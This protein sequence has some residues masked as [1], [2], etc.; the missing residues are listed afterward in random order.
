MDGLINL[1]A[2]VDLALAFAAMGFLAA[3]VQ[4]AVRG[5]HHRLKFVP[6][7]LIA[8]GL[9]IGLIISLVVPSST[10]WALSGGLATAEDGLIRHT[11]RI[12]ALSTM[13]VVVAMLVIGMWERL[14]RFG[15]KKAVQ[16]TARLLPATVACLLLGWL[17]L[18]VVAPSSAA[19]VAISHDIG[20]PELP[21]M[22][23]FAVIAVNSAI[24]GRAMGSRGLERIAFAAASIIPTI[25][26][27]AATYF[28]FV[29]L[30]GGGQLGREMASTLVGYP[31]PD[32]GRGFAFVGWWTAMY[33]VVVWAMGVG[34]AMGLKRGSHF[35]HRLERHSVNVVHTISS[36]A[37]AAAVGATAT[38]SRPTS[39][40]D[41]APTTSGRN[42]P[43]QGT[44]VDGHA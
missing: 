4:A 41:A 5:R 35:E 13:I 29:Q 33:L 37:V 43:P 25:M 24:I 8:G 1:M 27:V 14:R 6:F 12:W 15:F 34:M 28:L 19:A 32:D 17:V 44:S 3:Y 40:A 26:G 22:V 39:A 2:T 11:T 7:W 42:T 31:M 30:F 20:M 23:L 21:A 38:Q 16:S 10:R 18:F 36:S 9:P